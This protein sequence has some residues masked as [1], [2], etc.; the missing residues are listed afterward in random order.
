MQKNHAQFFRY[1]TYRLVVW[2]R[3]WAMKL[4][5]G[6]RKS[7]LTSAAVKVDNHAYCQNDISIKRWAQWTCT[8]PGPLPGHCFSLQPSFVMSQLTMVGSISC[9]S[10]KPST[11]FTS[12][13]TL[14]LKV[15]GTVSQF[16]KFEVQLVTLTITTN[17]H[18]DLCRLKVLLNM[19]TKKLLLSMQ[20]MDLKTNCGDLC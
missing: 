10:T 7:S 12:S 19:Y 15:S 3:T 20:I 9:S 4:F 14:M 16:S 1:F 8:R 17:R 2:G 11:N 5:A 6:G 13:G 18:G